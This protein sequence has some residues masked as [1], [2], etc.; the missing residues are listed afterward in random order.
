VH[1]VIAIHLLTAT[2]GLAA[3]LLSRVDLLGAWIVL[4]LVLSLLTLVAILES[5]GGKKL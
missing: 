2:C 4:I 1:A 3:V 5:A